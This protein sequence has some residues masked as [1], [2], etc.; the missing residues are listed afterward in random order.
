M[1]PTRKA[2]VFLNAAIMPV[3]SE[4]KEVCDEQFF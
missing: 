1:N 4:R 3:W 2:R